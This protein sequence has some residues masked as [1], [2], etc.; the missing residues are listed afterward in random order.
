MKEKIRTFSSNTELTARRREHIA[1]CAAHLF[2]EKGYSETGVHEV[3]NACEMSIGTLYHYVGSKEDIL[4]L[5]MDYSFASALSLIEDGLPADFYTITATE[6]LR[7]MIRSL[8][9]FTDQ[10]QDITLLIYQDM[11]HLMP[12]ARQRLFELEMQSISF[13]MDILRRG[14]DSGEFEINNIEMVAH[15]IVVITEMWAVRRWY[16]QPMQELQ[17]YIRQQTDFTLRAIS[18]DKA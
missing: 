18:K 7:H 8:C 5:V 13:V 3:A 11:R 9:E 14:C 6:A 12:G 4:S 1:R 17:E 2:V 15:N 16:V 10:V